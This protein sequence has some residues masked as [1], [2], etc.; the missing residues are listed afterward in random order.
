MS[1]IPKVI[2]YIWLGSE[3][4]KKVQRVINKNQQFFQGYKI[5]IWTEDNI[6]PLNRF[7]RYVYAEKKWAFVSDYLRFYI[8]YK[9]G[10]ISSG[11][12]SNKESLSVAIKNG[13]NKISAFYTY[14]TQIL[15]V[16]VVKASPTFFFK[17]IQEVKGS[18][19][20]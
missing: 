19:F 7:A 13:K 2:H 9:E 17:R 18:R 11:M 15:K 6:P 4:P 5:K 10:G 8:F 20:R 3:I 14:L 1:R 12:D 16:T